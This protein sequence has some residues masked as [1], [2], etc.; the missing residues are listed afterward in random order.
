MFPDLMFRLNLSS[1]SGVIPEF[2]AFLLGQT[3]V[4]QQVQRLAMG[5]AGS[6][7]NVSRTRLIEVS[8][9][10]PPYDM[11]RAFAEGLDGHTTLCQRFAQSGRQLGAL[12]DCMLHRAFTGD[13]TA[14]W[15]EAHMKELLREMEIQAREPGLQGEPKP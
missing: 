10:V 14:K 9:P 15:R 2:L 4:R 3:S 8:I 7:P 11:Q 5:A 13:L 12:F 1:S 6:M